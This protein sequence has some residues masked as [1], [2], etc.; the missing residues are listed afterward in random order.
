MEDYLHFVYWCKHNIHLYDEK[1]LLTG[2]VYDEAPHNDYEIN[3]I[4]F[5]LQTN[6]PESK[7]MRNAFGCAIEIQLNPH[8]GKVFENYLRNGII[9]YVGKNEGRHYYYNYDNLYTFE[10]LP[11]S[12]RLNCE[13]TNPENGMSNYKF[14]ICP[15]MHVPPKKIDLKLALKDI[16]RERTPRKKKIA[17]V[18]NQITDCEIKC[19]DGV[20]NANRWHLCMLND[21]FYTSMTNYNSTNARVFDLKDFSA[22]VFQQ[23]LYFSLDPTQAKT[24][25]IFENAIETLKLGMFFQDYKFV[26]FVYDLIAPNCDEESLQNL[27]DEVRYFFRFDNKTSKNWFSQKLLF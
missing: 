23:Y 16:L 7:T 20:V 19:S 25:V 27:N 24:D 10:S 14:K 26:K 12:E 22:I 1:V 17:R 3:L 2:S 8:S 5:L 21:Y 11:A 13:K 6:R 4:M 18:M 15:E 9:L